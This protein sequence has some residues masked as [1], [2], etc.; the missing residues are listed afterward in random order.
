VLDVGCQNVHVE[1]DG[2]LF[3]AGG[4]GLPRCLLDGSCNLR[5]V[6]RWQSKINA[7]INTKKYFKNFQLW[8]TVFLINRIT[9]YT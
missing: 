1:F 6:C 8:M 5:V 4:A 7:C 3:S 2:V 9:N